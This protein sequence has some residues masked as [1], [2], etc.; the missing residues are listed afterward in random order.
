MI[1]QEKKIQPQETKQSTDQTDM[2]Q[3]FELCH[4]EFKITITNMLKALF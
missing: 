3:M 2:V 4:R 1:K